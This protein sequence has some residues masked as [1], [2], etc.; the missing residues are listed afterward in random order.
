MA[1]VV[2]KRFTEEYTCIA[3]NPACV[4]KQN[5]YWTGEMDT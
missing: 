3:G 1:S 2:S 5:V 4:V